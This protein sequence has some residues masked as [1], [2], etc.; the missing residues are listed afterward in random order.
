MAYIA[1]IA[2]S[3]AI[4]AV[5]AVAALLTIAEG[6]SMMPCF[7]R[8]RRFSGRSFVVD[9]VRRRGLYDR[10]GI[11]GWRRG[12]ATTAITGITHSFL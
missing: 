5:P 8:D 4:A 11:V 3:R 9:V 2:D 12:A 10:L 1:I 7:V 6:V